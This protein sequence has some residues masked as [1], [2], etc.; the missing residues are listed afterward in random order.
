MGLRILTHF[1]EWG[2]ILN[3][4]SGN[5]QQNLSRMWLWMD[6]NVS[7]FIWTP[8]MISIV[9]H[10]TS[11]HFRV[12]VCMSTSPCDAIPRGQIAC[13]TTM[14]S[15]LQY[16]KWTGSA[17]AVITHTFPKNTSNNASNLVTDVK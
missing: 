8:I 13:K 17:L 6:K 16:K 14:E 5:T 15:Y 2:K 10:E 11:A 1:N 9:A 4:R 12:R 7:I 3:V